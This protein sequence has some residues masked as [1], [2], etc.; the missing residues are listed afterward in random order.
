LLNY[1]LGAGSGYVAAVPEVPEHL[2]QRSRERREALG[3]ASSSGA[4]A[5]PAAEGEAS[6]AP[7]TTVA[8]TPAAAPAPA[9]VEEPVVPVGPNP[10]V[11]KLEEA[12]QRKIPTWVFPVLVGL[13]LWAIL[14][15]G[16]FGS[17][18]TVVAETPEQIGA[19]VYASAGCSGCHGAR[20]EGA[21]GPKLASGEAKLT[22]PNE[23]DQIDWIKTGSQTKPVGTPYGDPARPSGQHVVR[24][25]GMPAFQGKLSD[26]EIEAVAKYERDNL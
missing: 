26:A 19:R 23:A 24:S 20:G 4:A 12:R 10:I 1:P 5:A 15:I 16:A 9:V 13:P 8:P 25:G 2:L 18:K 17:H 14:Y 3:L 21:V 22:F 7:T 6:A 11:L